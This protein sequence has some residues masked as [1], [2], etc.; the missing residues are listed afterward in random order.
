MTKWFI[1]SEDETTGPLSTEQVKSLHKNDLIKE[2]SL[3]WSRHL[4]EWKLLSEWISNVDDDLSI[5]EIKNAKNW[6]F[7]LNQ[8]KFGPYTREALIEHLVEHKEQLKNILLW[9]KG[10]KNWNSLFD[11]LDII[12][13]LGINARQIPRASI[14]GQLLIKS[15]ND[16]I[17]FPTS[18]ISE[19]GLGILNAFGL[20]VGEEVQGE[21]ISPH[22]SNRIY[23]N[24]EVRYIDEHGFAGLMYTQINME[25]KQ[26]IVN[27]IKGKLSGVSSDTNSHSNKKAA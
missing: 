1:M 3:I 22:F 6:Y 7:A 20:Q 17:P 9:T 12:D 21:F 15:N 13:E 26:A 27:Y 8:K 11:F 16:K 24:A 10:M 14:E 23:L 2:S 4:N 19:N 18:T 5:N 25:A